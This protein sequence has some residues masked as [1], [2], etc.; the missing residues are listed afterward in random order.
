MYRENKL[1][2]PTRMIT[3]VLQEL[4]KTF[5]HV[6]GNRLKLLF[7]KRCY[8]KMTPQELEEYLGS[9]PS[10]GSCL[11]VKPSTIND[12]GKFGSLLVP[13]LANSL[14]YLDFTH[15]DQS[16]AYDYRINHCGQSD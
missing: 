12:R 13:S 9:L 3:P 8:S 4:H 1:C 7:H 14:V 15:L 2:V 11:R 5:G 16:G 6:Q 10:C